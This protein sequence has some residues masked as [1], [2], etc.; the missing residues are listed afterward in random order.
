MTCFVFSIEVTANLLATIM[1]ISSKLTVSCSLHVLRK[2]SFASNDIYIVLPSAI[3]H[4]SNIYN[5][6]SYDTISHEAV[7][8]IVFSI[9]VGWQLVSTGALKHTARLV[10]RVA[11]ISASCCTVE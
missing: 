11:C 8:F 3:K 5:K 6:C 10:M 4:P 1:F 2:A 9:N 7:M